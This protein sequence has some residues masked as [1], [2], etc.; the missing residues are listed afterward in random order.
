MN[1]D[2]KTN[3]TVDYGFEVNALRPVTV[4]SEAIQNA[5]CADAHSHPRAQIISCD[6]GIMEVVTEHTIWIVNPLQGVWIASNEEHQVY[7]PNNVK[8]V[9]AFIDGSKLTNLPSSSFAF[10]I[11]T[12]FRSLLAKVV[13]FSNP[14]RL[15]S[16]QN[17]IFDVLLDEISSLKPSST[18][19]PTSHDGRIK[20]VTDALMIDFSSKHTI[21]Y[22]ANESCVSSKTLSRLF[23]KELGMSF[24]E[25]KMRLKLLEAV[26]QLGENRTIKDIAYDLGYE[27]VSSFIATFKKYFGKTPANYM[28][29]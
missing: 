25:W 18:F 14:D 19:L 3:I 6:R 16:Q 10:D 26:R 20:K 29:E 13:S 5:K 24:G 22:Y 15:T 23:V 21:D 9:S 7:F 8:V 2:Y 28:I 11:T 17:R 4:Y 27:N 12:F 1:N